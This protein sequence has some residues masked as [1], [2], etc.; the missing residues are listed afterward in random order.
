[1]GRHVPATTDLSLSPSVY[2]LHLPVSRY[3]F[4]G[5][6]LQIAARAFVPTRPVFISYL[7]SVAFGSG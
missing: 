3:Q 7:K 6:C 4:L 1:M 5:R 2:P